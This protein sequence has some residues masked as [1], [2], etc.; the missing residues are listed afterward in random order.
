MRFNT[1]WYY[2]PL[3][4]ADSLKFRTARSSYSVVALPSLQLAAGAV[5]GTPG[6]PPGTCLLQLH[7]GNTQGQQAF[8]LTR[9]SCPDGGWQ[10]HD[11]QQ[12]QQQQEGGLVVLG[13]KDEA[14]TGSSSTASSSS[15]SALLDVAVK[16]DTTATLHFSLRPLPTGTSLPAAVQGAE[17]HLYQQGHRPVSGAGGGPTTRAAE[18]QRQ[19]QQRR[20]RQAADAPA[21]QSPSTRGEFS[22]PLDLLLHWEAAS[23]LDGTLRQGYHV[24][25][26]QK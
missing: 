6:A 17:L 4:R 23:K 9:F 24:L 22:R 25:Y 11:L 18:Q 1:V 16:R 14:G 13:L 3:T 5:A 15:A 19:E 26:H 12:Q 20:R 7:A 8:R 2:E 21:E 10:L